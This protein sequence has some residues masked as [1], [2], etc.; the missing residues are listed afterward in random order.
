MKRNESK[1][2]GFDDIIFE[3][4]NK[5][6]GAYDL[7]K[8]YNRTAAFSVISGAALSAAI[9]ILITATS[10]GEITA[11][12]DKVLYI[13]VKP[14]NAVLPE[15]VEQPEA[16][17][18]V[19][20]SVPYKYLAPDVTEDSINVTDMLIND[21]AADSVMNGDITEDIDSVVFDMTI[22]D[23]TKDPEPLVIV[24]EPP[25]FP[26]GEEALLAFIAQNI[27]YP[28]EAVENNIQGRVFMKFAVRA[29]GSVDRIE[30]LKGVHPLLDQEAARVVA[31]LPS[32]KP[33]RQ[34]GTPV[35]V[36]FNMPVTFKLIER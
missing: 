1:N 2:P 27:R 26:G 14:D 29:D 30:V 6:Y 28:Q 4:R 22:V 32:W 35:A 31:S 16:P 13:V 24:E 9:L 23:D 34:N 18:Q 8:R 10:P 21:F 25:L 19:T 20:K 36:W 12:P 5:D 7:R 17:K 33:G 3:S 15:K 11:S